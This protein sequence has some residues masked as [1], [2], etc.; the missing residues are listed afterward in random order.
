M[1]HIHWVVLLHTV[2]LSVGYISTLSNKLEKPCKGSF[3]R[4]ASR[5]AYAMFGFPI[6][7]QPRAVLRV[8]CFRP[9]CNLHCLLWTTWRRVAIRSSWKRLWYPRSGT[10]TLTIY[11]AE[12]VGVPV[13]TAVSL[14]E[15]SSSVWRNF[16]LL[17]NWNTFSDVS[18]FFR[19]P[20]WAHFGSR[21]CFMFCKLTSMVLPTP[22]KDKG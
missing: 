10:L 19:L 16:S 20:K 18:R 7:V 15:D 21:T 1:S 11:G 8:Q 6:T 9:D 5:R 17:I 3:N 22:G 12:A 2:C 13:G 14:M 4:A